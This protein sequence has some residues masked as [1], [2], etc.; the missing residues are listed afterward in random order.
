MLYNGHMIEYLLVM[1]ASERSNYPLQKSSVD[2]FVRCNSQW[3]KGI[4]HCCDTLATRASGKIKAKRE[5]N[6]FNFACDEDK[7]VGF[8]FIVAVI[9][10]N[11]N[12][13]SVTRVKILCCPVTTTVVFVN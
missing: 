12:L 5:Q 9:Q 2:T 8:F 10:M 1:I 11:N 7:I 13:S 3:F 6:H 4:V